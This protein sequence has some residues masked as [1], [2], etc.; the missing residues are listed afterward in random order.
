M[1][2]PPKAMKYMTCRVMPFRLWQSFFW[3]TQGTNLPPQWYLSHSIYSLYVSTTSFHLFCLIAVFFVFC[4][5][6]SFCFYFL[7]STFPLSIYNFLPLSVHRFPPGAWPSSANSMPQ[8][9]T[10]RCSA[11]IQKPHINTGISPRDYLSV[12]CLPGWVLLC[13]LYSPMNRVGLGKRG[14][15]GV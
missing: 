12:A 10:T 3:P 11:M 8:N 4:F 14:F 1:G 13:N 9:A 2:H 7:I 6:L 5:F 15:G